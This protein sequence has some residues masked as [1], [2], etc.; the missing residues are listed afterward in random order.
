MP[1]PSNNTITAQLH[2]IPHNS[3]SPIFKI[4]HSNCSSDKNTKHHN[5][6]PTGTSLP[7]FIHIFKTFYFNGSKHNTIKTW[8][9]QT[10]CC[11]K[12]KLFTTIT[13]TTVE[14]GLYMHPIMSVSQ[15]HQYI[16][17]YCASIVFSVVRMLITIP[18]L[19][20]KNIIIIKK[21]PLIMSRSWGYNH[22]HHE[23]QI[24][25]SILVGYF[26]MMSINTRAIINTTVPITSYF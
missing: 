3:S 17:N 7:P 1:L 12:L 18:C 19:W 6:S 22:H 4:F 24:I 21:Q 15:H 10:V 20:Q 23:V 5:C 16:S 11:P 13:N 26:V 14:A 8:D 2:S 25:N 9:H